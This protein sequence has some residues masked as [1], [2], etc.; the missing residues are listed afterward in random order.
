MRLSQG[1]A[2]TSKNDVARLHSSLYGPK[3]APEAW[4]EKLRSTLL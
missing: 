4:F 1:C 3:Q 2:S